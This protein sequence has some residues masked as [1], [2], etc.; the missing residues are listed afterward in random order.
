V[1]ILQCNGGAWTALHVNAIQTACQATQPIQA[2]DFMLISDAPVG[3]RTIAG[4]KAVRALLSS[5]SEIL[6]RK[7]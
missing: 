3:P 4:E 7:K 5:C 2:N 1:W 6:H